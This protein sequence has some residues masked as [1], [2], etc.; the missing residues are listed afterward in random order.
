MAAFLIPLLISLAVNVAAY[1]ILPKPKQGKPA[2][3]AQ[4]EAPTADAGKPVMVVFGTVT[5]SE[6]NVLFYTDKSQRDFKVAA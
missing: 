6:L 5:V 3:A 2:A 4:L 1:L